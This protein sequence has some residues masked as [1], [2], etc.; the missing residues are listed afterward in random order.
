MTEQKDDSWDA[1]ADYMSRAI[2]AAQID[3]MAKHDR[4]LAALPTER[5]RRDY[6][7]ARGMYPGPHYDASY[8]ADPRAWWERYERENPA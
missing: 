7:K 3:L 8:H 6:M 5:E 4:E 1:L 2:S